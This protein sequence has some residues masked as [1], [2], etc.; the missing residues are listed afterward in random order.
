VFVGSDPPTRPL[1]L[2]SEVR[3]LDA[4]RAT[5]MPAAQATTS[6]SGL[7]LVAAEGGSVLIGGDRGDDQ[8]FTT[9]CL[10]EQGVIFLE[11]RSQAQ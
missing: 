6:A 8:W 10:L 5:V 3:F 4:D 11:D 7:A 2:G 1:A 9:G